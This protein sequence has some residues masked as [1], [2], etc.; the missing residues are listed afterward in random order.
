M[1]AIHMFY[2][3]LSNKELHQKTIA[4]AATEKNATVALLEF[5][6]E[7]ERRRLYAER[8]YPSLW[9]YVHREL[10]Y[11]EAQTSERVGA[12]RL[13]ARLPQV[14]ER[15]EADQLSLT[16]A[17]K[18]AS[19]A[20]KEKLAAEKTLE[21]L[22]RIENKPKREVEK[23][24]FAEQAIPTA[25]PDS[26]RQASVDVTRISFDADEE[27]MELFTRLKDLQA[28]QTLPMQVVLKKAIKE[29][30]GKRIVKPKAAMADENSQR[31]A[32]SPAEVKPVQPKKPSRYVPTAVK[33]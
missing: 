29:Y 4:A 12:M 7:V 15:L 14:R 31:T 30:V 16:T 17:A 28:D 9:M 20:K 25:R 22:H 32:S 23:I 19:F 13:M 33:K 26:I 1:L 18:L 21:L 3:S 8:G 11:S 27:F 6:Q 10:H 2:L 24:L 5:L